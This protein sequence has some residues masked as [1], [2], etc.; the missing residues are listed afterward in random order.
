MTKIFFF[1]N[2]SA[3]V[4]TEYK[5]RKDHRVITEKPIWYDS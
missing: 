5:D 1:N 4:S 3:D 2:G